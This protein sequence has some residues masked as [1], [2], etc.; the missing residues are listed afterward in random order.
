MAVIVEAWALGISKVEKLGGS[1]EFAF[2]F[3][4][5]ARVMRVKASALSSPPVAARISLSE[6]V[7]ET[8][9]LM[10]FWWSWVRACHVRFG[11]RSVMEEIDAW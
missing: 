9:H 7:R 5:A 4:F 11:S 1:D 2:A 3:A 8:R 10:L 6:R